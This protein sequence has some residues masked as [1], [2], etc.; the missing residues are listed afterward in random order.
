MDPRKLKIFCALYEHQ[1]FTR[2]AKS[3][4]LSQPSVSEHIQGLELQLE[5]KLFDRVGKTAIPT[6]SARLLHKHA[7]KILTQINRAKTEISRIGK[8]DEGEL[9]IGASSLPGGYILPALLAGFQADYPKIRPNIMIESSKIIASAVASGELEIGFVGFKTKASGLNWGIWKKDQ[10]ALALSVNH[11]GAAQETFTLEDLKN[12]PLLMREEDSGSRMAMMDQLE[13]KRIRLKDL[14]ISAQL[15]SLEAI[16][17]GVCQGLGA[18]LISTQALNGNSSKI[19]LKQVE[20]LSLER[21]LYMITAK[22]RPLSY[23]AELFLDKI[24]SS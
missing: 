11:P 16:L 23:L 8:V 20:G 14:Q 7:Q 1:S 6:E 12:T 18:S 22:G 24:Q 19:I 2:A 13:K 4:G 3:L 9:R 17:N 15:G 21:N 10:M 5:Q